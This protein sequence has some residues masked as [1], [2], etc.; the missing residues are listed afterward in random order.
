[1]PGTRLLRKLRCTSTN[2]VVP[3]LEDAF[4]RSVPGGLEFACLMQES[5]DRNAAEW[6][7]PERRVDIEVAVQA[8]GSRQHFQPFRGVTKV[9]IG[10]SPGKI[11]IAVIEFS[12]CGRISRSRLIARCHRG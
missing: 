8:E 10:K 2:A 4:G 1:M 3:A 12:K 5:A 7:Q 6:F 9:E 11:G